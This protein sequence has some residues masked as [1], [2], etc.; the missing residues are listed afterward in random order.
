[1]TLVSVLILLPLLVAATLLA[2]RSDRLRNILVVVASV[3]VAAVSLGLLTSYFSPERIESGLSPHLIDQAM[4]FVEVAIGVFLLYLCLKRRRYMVALLVVV[5]TALM[6]GFELRYGEA[7]SVGPHLFADKF[8]VIMA[9]IIGLPGTLIA[10]YS[11]GY[12]KEYHEHHGELRDK[13]PLFFFLIFL[14]LSAM[15]GIVFSNHL[16]WLYFFW[17][18]TT[19]CSFLLIGYSET[20]EAVDNAF[21]ALFYNLIGGLAMAV[22]VILF[23]K[24]T[25]NIGLDQML[26]TPHAAAALLPA[27]LIAIAGL[28]KSAQMPF[29]SWLLGA[30]V[31]PTPVSALLHSST[32]VKAGVYVVIRMA[33]IFE[34]TTSG[35]AIALIGGLTFLL[36][37]ILC[38]PQRNS[39]R[40]LAYSTIANL[41]LIV[42]CGGIG[43][44]AAVWA[45]ILLI[46]FHAVT[47]CLLFLCVGSIE[48]RLGSRDIEDMGGLVL[49][50]PRVSV[51][52]QIGMAGMFVAPFGMLISKW[53]VLKA[54]V[55]CNPAVTVFVIFGSAATLFVWVKWLGKL[56]EVVRPVEDVEQTVSRSERFVLHALAALTI[57]ICAGY[58]M[59]STHLIE[60]YV[61]DIYGHVTNL[62]RG[63]VIIMLIMLGMVALFPLSFRH[64]GRNVKVLDAYL[65]GANTQGSIQFLGSAGTVR[66]V[67][68]TNYYLADYIDERRVTRV[69]GA[70]CLVL[71]AMAAGVSLL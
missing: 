53:A 65:G 61:M 29:S 17:E 1:M 50:M 41:G 2:V 12:M 62:G 43:T 36:A 28:A 9:L 38:I 47:K 35:L 60:P 8:S 11:L 58:P 19:L 67:T 71:M 13:R 44:Y 57:A 24:T 16:V 45:G 42:L 27:V 15:F 5:Q 6:T 10:I 21:R 46:I 14:F 51:M 55:D 26:K 63:N 18:I 34:G 33:P 54:L 20:E 30:M 3:A 22:G 56:I 70:V 68:M 52:L 69:G 48:H 40:L 31:A 49:S 7:L 25:G 64:Y 39:K 23:Y 4:L 59:L 32:M 37:S 66:D